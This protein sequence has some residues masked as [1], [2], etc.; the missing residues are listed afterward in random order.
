MFF[1]LFKICSSSFACNVFTGLVW[2]RG[3]FGCWTVWNNTRCFGRFYRKYAF[4]HIN[5]FDYWSYN[6]CYCFCWSKNW[7]R[8]TWRCWKSNWNWNCAFFNFGTFNF[9]PYNHF[10]K[11]TC[12]INARSKRS[13]WSNLPL[14]SS[15]WG[16]INFYRFF[17]IYLEQ[18]FVELEIQ[19]HRLLQLPL[20]VL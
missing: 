20:P 15:L 10:Y 5:K 8:K 7:W 9:C 3:S 19:K 11:T 1:P 2:R 17:T 13:L 6:G 18:F 4:A 16:R 12:N 14:H